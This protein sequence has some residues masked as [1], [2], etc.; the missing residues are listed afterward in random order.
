M[1]KKS[2]RANNVDPDT[3][4]QKSMKIYNIYIF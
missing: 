3:E 2:E 1:K 4:K